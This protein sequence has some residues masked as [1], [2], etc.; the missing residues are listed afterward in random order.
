MLPKHRCCFSINVETAAQA[1]KM[2]QPLLLLSY[3]RS[4]RLFSLVFSFFVL[5][6]L[7]S[8]INKS[9]KLILIVG[10]LGIRETFG[11]QLIYL[12]NALD[13]IFKL[14]NLK[15]ISYFKD[16]KYNFFKTCLSE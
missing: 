2:M 12:L 3:L 4:E 6:K 8:T 10:K 16:Q 1:E 9:A 7:N 11:E 5:K 14:G 13:S 15:E